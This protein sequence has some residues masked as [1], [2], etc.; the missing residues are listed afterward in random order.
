[1]SFNR[2]PYDNCAYA[3]QLQ[4][5]VT[6]MEYSL[7]RGKY[8]NCKQCPV[9]SYTNVLDFTVRANVERNNEVTNYS[10]REFNYNSF[11]REFQLPTNANSTETRAKYENGILT[12]MLPKNDN[13]S[14]TRTVKV[15]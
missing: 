4:E 2:L 15:S 1:M 3:K 6:P 7:F 13:T 14:N 10:Y 11:T 8:E 9:G 12:I 5:S